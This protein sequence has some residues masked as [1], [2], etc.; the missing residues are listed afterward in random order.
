[1]ADPVTL[2]EARLH[3]RLPS[4]IT[5]DEQNEITRLISVATEYAEQFTN[6]LWTTGSRV[7][8]F[9]AFPYSVS[10]KR[11]G[12]YL[13]GGNISSI[14]SITYYDANYAQQTLASSEY[15]LVGAPE[16][17]TVYPGMG[18]EWP[19]DVANEPDHIAVTY[20][21]DGTVGVPAAVK[22]AVLLTVGALYEYREDGVI[23]NAGLALVKAPKAAEDLLTPYRIRIA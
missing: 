9:D 12:L 6:R 14:T 2:A 8:T 15:R 23:D 5:T 20:A 10:R 4:N 18:K 11:Q 17:A 22:Q 21:L 3:L 7:E 13:P 16:R 1:M 19:T